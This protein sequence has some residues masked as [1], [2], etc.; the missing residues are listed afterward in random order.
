MIIYIKDTTLTP[1]QEKQFNSYPRAVQY[2]EGMSQ[3]AYG[4]TRKQR[5][6]LLEE[7]GHGADDP[8]AVTFVRTMAQAFDIG[9]V[10][11]GA[12]LPCDITTIPLYQ[13]EE[14]GD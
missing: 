7:L 3:R 5:M 8:N 11:D 10:R 12:H 6:I 9:V 13:K 1:S 4:Q 2:L 14:F